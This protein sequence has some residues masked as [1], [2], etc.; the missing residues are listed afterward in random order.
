[1]RVNKDFCDK[2]KSSGRRERG[3]AESAEKAFYIADR[4]R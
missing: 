2:V 3:R 1:M 4:T